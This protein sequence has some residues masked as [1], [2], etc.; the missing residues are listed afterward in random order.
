[1]TKEHQKWFQSWFNTTYYH[2]LYKNRDNKEA[3]LFI[4]N[5]IY[6]L[7]LIPEKDSILDLACGQ[8]RHSKYLNS[9]G[10][11]V[12]GIDTSLCLDLKNSERLSSVTI[13]YLLDAYNKTPKTEK[14]FG[15]TFTV[16]AGNLELE[17]QLK[18][19]LS[20]KEIHDSWQP[21]IEDF[22]KVRKK[23]LIYE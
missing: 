2:I 23:Y 18:N 10:Y 16:H 21:A 11:N 20:A 5:L 8:G 14:F 12:T 17:Q 7:N 13:E 3:E 9:L 6:Y 22:K 1:M 15:A 4:S 19:G